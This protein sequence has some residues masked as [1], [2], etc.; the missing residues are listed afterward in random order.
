MKK[1]FISA[2]SVLVASFS[3][4]AA[5]PTVYIQ[6]FSNPSGT[7]D[8]WVQS[9]RG[10]VLQGLQKSGR[11]T[12]VDAVAEQSRFDEEMRRL[13]GNLD[14]Q[15]LS[16]TEALKT[17]GAH[18]ILTGDVNSVKVTS[19]TLSSGT[20]SYD[21]TASY[22]LKVVNASDGAMV[23][24]ETY[25]LPANFAKGL[26]NVVTKA[27][28]ESEDAAVGNILGDATGSMKKFAAKAF[29]VVGSVEDVDQL[30]KNGKEV[31]TLYVGLGSEDGLVKGTKLDVKL[32]QKIGKRT[33]LK[34]IGVCQV[35]E[36]AG[37]DISLCEVK[38]GGTEIKNAID[39]GQTLKVETQEK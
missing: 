6:E 24:T 39:A 17:L 21:A 1:L 9:I 14:T 18:Y 11:V 27:V 28:A 7:K 22:T 2:F 30:S 4:F 15:D 20:V 33:A 19:S 36:I 10:A 12:I 29:P 31:K 13:K 35:E 32:E 26:L 34:T 38:K 23:M 16:T 37:D 8:A 5:K 3:S 25:S